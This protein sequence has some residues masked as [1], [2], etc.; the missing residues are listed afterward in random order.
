MGNPDTHSFDS[1]TEQGS[2]AG[3]GGEF[4]L[5]T[6]SRVAEYLRQHPEDRRSADEIMVAGRKAV[7]QKELEAAMQANDPQAIA[8]LREQWRALGQD[9]REA[10]TRR[11]KLGHRQER[12]FGV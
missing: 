4:T 10:Y 7:V 5:D 3:E 1:A 11:D 2:T 8:R 12:K 6:D 9:E